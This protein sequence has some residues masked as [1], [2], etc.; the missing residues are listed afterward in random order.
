MTIAPLLVALTLIAAWWIGEL[1]VWWLKGHRDGVHI[2]DYHLA[3]DPQ[4]IAELTEA[5]RR[6]RRRT[7]EATIYRLRPWK[8]DDPERLP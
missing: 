8:H 3:R 2:R 7:P 4:F 1:T 6:S 5:I